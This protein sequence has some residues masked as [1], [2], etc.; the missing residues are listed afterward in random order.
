ML[1]YRSYAKAFIELTTNLEEMV[2]ATHVLMQ[3]F[4]VG[5]LIKL[6]GNPRILMAERIAVIEEI[7]KQYG[8]PSLLVKFACVVIT[9]HRHEKFNLIF[10][11]YRK[12]IFQ[13]LGWLRADVFSATPLS[14][15][16]I[17][18]L[19]EVFSALTQRKVVFRN[20]VRPLVLHGVKILIQG[21][22]LDNTLRAHTD[23][24]RQRCTE[25][26]ISH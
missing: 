6:F 23:R 8:L 7:G 12:L 17:E 24:L 5:H 15:A 26:L 21:K 13:H 22:M 10:H 14:E 3:A 4:E 16:E 25:E 1:Y 9:N 18:R 11:F 2:D 19:T 20:L